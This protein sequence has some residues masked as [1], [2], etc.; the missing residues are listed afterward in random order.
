MVKK[1]ASKVGCPLK[2]SS[3]TVLDQND[4]SFFSNFLVFSDSAGYL[5]FLLK[6]KNPVNSAGEAVNTNY[7]CV[8][9]PRTCSCFVGMLASIF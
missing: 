2:R 5:S 3:R 4:W 1:E 8:I 6:K 9:R 7:W